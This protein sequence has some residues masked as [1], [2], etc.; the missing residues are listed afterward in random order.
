MIKN[1]SKTEASQLEKKVK[2]LKKTK[3]EAALLTSEE[4][5]HLLL[6]SS[7]D[8]IYLIDRELK[9]LYANQKLL[10]RYGKSLSEVTGQSYAKFHSPE[11]TELFSNRVKEVIKSGKPLAYEYK[12]KRDEKDFL[13][14]LNP[15]INRDT[16][17][18]TAITVI[19][20]D[21]SEQK[22]TARALEKSE[23]K[24]R[25]FIDSS[26]I[27][28]WCFRLE[29]PVNIALPKEKMIK[30]FF[31]TVCVEC[32]ETY[33]TMMGTSKDEILGTVLYEVMPDT[34]ENRDYLEAFIQNNFRISDGISHEIDKNGIEKYF[35]NSMVGTIKN[36]KLIEAWGT[37]TDITDLKHT[38]KKIRLLS[39]ITENSP[40]AMV[41][42]DMNKK[43]TYVNPFF[44]KLYGYDSEEILNKPVAILSGEDDPEKHY[45]NIF[46]IIRS[47]GLWRGHD[48][49]KRK[50]GTIFWASSSV[51]EI[52]DEKG[53]IFCYSEASRDITQQ[54]RMEDALHES[55]EL[56]RTIFENITIGMYRT[57]PDGRILKANPALVRMLGY[58]SFEELAQ[59]NLED[60]GYNSKYP[61]TLFKQRIESEGEVAGMESAWTRRDGVT[62]F[63]RENSKAI[64]DD[65]GNTIF[66]EGT[67]EDIT[68]R[69]R[70]KEALKESELKLRSLFNAMSD[71]ILE[72]DKDGRFISIAPTSTNFLYKPAEKIIGKTTHEI[73]P[74]EYADRFQEAIQRCFDENKIVK[75]EYSL[76]IKDK[77]RW[78]E[79]TL[80]P[81]TEDTILFIARDIT[82]SK[83][84]AD[85][86][87]L[88]TTQIEK[89]SKIS[90]DM[91]TITDDK[92]LFKTISTAIVEISDFSRVLFYTFKEDFP[93][94]DILGYH[95]LDKKTIERLKKVGVSR[96]ELG[97]IFKKG[98]PLGTQSCYIPHTK[99]DLLDQKAVNNGK[100]EYAPG[101]G[102]WHR[103]DNL[104]IALSDEAGDLIG[105]ISIDDSKSGLI[106]TDETV[107]PLEMF[108][109][110]IS[111]ILQSRKLAKQIRDSEEQYRL[112]VE[113]VNDAIVIS[114]Y[115]KFIF[116]NK[117][118]A[119]MLGYE[120]DELLMKDF[121]EVHTEKAVE[122]LVKRD[123]Q[124]DRREKVPSRYETIFKKK[125]GKL[126]DV[127]ANVT[128]IDYRGDKA[129]F[130]VIRDVTERKRIEKE[131]HRNQ[132]LE[133]IGVLAGGI[134]H[135]FNNILTIILGNIS[136]SKMYAK[137][138]DKVYK[139][140]IEAEKGAMR[141]KDLTQQLLT[142][143]KG[144]APV[145]E[146]SS[147]AEFLKESAAFVLSGSNVKCIFSIPDDIW[148]IEI[149]KGQINQV[150]NNL[151]MNADQAMPEGGIINIKA[152]NIIITSENVLLLQKG[153]YLKISLKDHGIG[154]LADHLDKIFNP[155]FS[156]KTKGS[157]LGLTSAYSIIRN[158]NGLITVESELGIGTTFYIYLPA[159]EKIVAEKESGTGKPL[160]GKGKILIMDDEDFVREVAG[161]MVESLGYSAEFAKDGAEA[162]ELYK[163]AMES[164]KPFAAVIMDLTIPG[165]MGGKEAIRELLKIDPNAKAI[166]SSGYSSDPIMSDCKKY[167]F[168]GVVAKPYKIS[169]LGKTL[170]KIIRKTNFRTAK[171]D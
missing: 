168:M 31:K 51:T 76:T 42:L 67:I 126:I 159:L 68:E 101:K 41:V 62:L 69:K 53:N 43:I 15:F 151:V 33:A 125:D 21:I 54:K 2:K 152:E 36:G 138:E 46:N 142:F 64:R 133:S 77:E 79:G 96:E 32:N 156:T 80:S 112:L 1:H 84:A 113:N 10:S 30:A 88:L 93:Y 50:D 34:E 56:F 14:T 171:P 22:Q 111:Q 166:V 47:K 45:S 8:P 137:S 58:S 102:R 73:F 7:D 6:E 74:K 132:N 149:D 148:A 11:A 81:K 165:G 120:Y 118:F 87:R 39:Q 131:A 48:R 92:K 116:F 123:Q 103:E 106:P 146:T 89:F 28:I 127:E 16:R 140:L 139:R 162:I 23:E 108:A 110:H 109:N 61:R 153:K 65:A 13:R 86:I 59:R 167:G 71:L 3:T 40:V 147:V 136:L 169:E 83:I 55:E 60:A 114:Q 154:I 75:L 145:K 155:Y 124:R 105:M 141:A 128:I 117:Q 104:F 98:I 99:K 97:T 49:R 35:S 122:I 160:F 94:R 29:S 100:K 161:E 91:V 70:A 130:A 18:I 20:K 134:A 9:Y 90:A 19:S 38:E 12:S 17:E 57:T 158:H 82:E 26:T 170:Q 119:I 163:N 63:V 157:G 4:K 144:G 95:G 143:S 25:N 150:F 107:K 129:T 44:L 72:I 24:L 85:R 121:T 66:Y 37:Q 5:F 115:D 27:G 135:D 52:K 78:F 164:G